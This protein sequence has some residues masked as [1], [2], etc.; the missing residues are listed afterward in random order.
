MPIFQM[1]AM[2]ALLAKKAAAVQ[3]NLQAWEV[4]A[5]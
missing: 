3:G 5:S 1:D 4:I 2:D